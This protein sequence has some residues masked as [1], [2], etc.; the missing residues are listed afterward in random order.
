[1]RG[2]VTMKLSYFP[3]LLSFAEKI[4]L[5]YLLYYYLMSMEW[6]CLIKFVWG[7][8]FGGWR[9]APGVPYNFVCSWLSKTLITTPAS[10]FEPPYRFAFKAARPLVLIPTNKLVKPITTDLHITM[11]YYFN[12]IKYSSKQIHLTYN[13]NTNTKKT[14]LQ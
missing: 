2:H 6:V 4:S 10:K 9:R 13:W 7:F 12:S 1:M 11:Y 3:H 14:F 8:P 5:Y